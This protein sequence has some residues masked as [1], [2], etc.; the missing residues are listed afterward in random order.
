MRTAIEPQRWVLPALP[1]ATPQHPNSM[2]L[3]PHL[4]YP[5]YSAEY[6]VN[7][8]SPP[9]ANGANMVNFFNGA[10]S[11]VHADVY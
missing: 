8:Q 10:V 5:E 9:H 11:H 3:Q 2:L 7:M 6:D 4:N 1:P